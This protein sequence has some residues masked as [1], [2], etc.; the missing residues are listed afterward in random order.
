ME[1]TPSLSPSRYHES[2]SSSEEEEEEEGV[3]ASRLQ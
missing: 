2:E 3:Y 1:R